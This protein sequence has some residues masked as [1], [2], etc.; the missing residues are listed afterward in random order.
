MTMRL[1]KKNLCEELNENLSE[2][3]WNNYE[4]GRYAFVSGFYCEH[5]D[6][7]WFFLGLF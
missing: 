5:K 6:M 7:F 3:R 4:N 1:K 2:H